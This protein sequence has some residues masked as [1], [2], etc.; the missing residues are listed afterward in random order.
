MWMVLVMLIIAL[1]LSGIFL[2]IKYSIKKSEEKKYY[3]A[4]ARM[5]KENCLN[6]I[7]QNRGQRRQTV[8]DKLMIYISISGKS[9]QGFVFDPENGIRIGRNI[10]EN[11]ICIRDALVS[12]SHCNIYLYQGK[13]IIQDFNSANGTFIKR[14]LFDKHPV[15]GW[16]YIYSGDTL[17]IG[18]TSITIKFF[19][20]DIMRL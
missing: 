4:A 7:I 19:L 15:D 9:R 2:W 10:E 18:D 12:S 13:P 1:A 16:E 8:T 6:K 5:I 17:L 14:G 11:E 20:F 3:D